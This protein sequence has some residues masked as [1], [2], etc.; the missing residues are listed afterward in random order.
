MDDSQKQY[1]RSMLE[2]NRGRLCVKDGHV[3]AIVTFF[4]GDDD[5]KYLYR[6][7]W[8]IIP[9]DPM[10]STVYIDQ[11]LIKDKA[12]FRRLHSEF[13]DFMDWVKQDFTN[14][15]RAKWVRVNAAFRKHGIKEGVKSN[16]HVKNI[17]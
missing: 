16:V 10:G 1:Y 8:T 4:I 7:P 17:K 15:K 14:V 3:I 2:N 13:T 12:V 6:D 9:D 5:E 11:L